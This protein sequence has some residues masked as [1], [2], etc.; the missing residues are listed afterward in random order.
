MDV[1][2]NLEDLEAAARK[3][4]DSGAHHSYID[5]VMNA[6]AEIKELRTMRRNFHTAMQAARCEE[7]EECAQMVRDHARA[8]SKGS[9]PLPR[10]AEEWGEVLAE[11]IETSF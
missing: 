11:Q 3:L 1:P 10:S 2:T 4:D 6:V 7:K 8:I 5:E 9:F